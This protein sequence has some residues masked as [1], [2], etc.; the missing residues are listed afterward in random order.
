[1]NIIY[2]Y[3][4]KYEKYTSLNIRNQIILN[5]PIITKFFFS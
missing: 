5:S 1:M 4:Y 3:Y 2:V